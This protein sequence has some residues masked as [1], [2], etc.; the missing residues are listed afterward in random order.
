MSAYRKFSDG[1]EGHAPDHL[2]QVCARSQ[3]EAATSQTL[4]TLVAR[5]VGSDRARTLGG[6]G[7]LGAPNRSIPAVE[8]PRKAPP[9]PP[10]VPKPPKVIR[11][12]LVPVAY[13]AAFADLEKDCPTGV[14]A[15]RWQQCIQDAQRFFDGWGV[16][17]IALG[18]GADDL[19][20]LDPVA[21]LTR[22]DVMGLVWSLQGSPVVA[23]TADAAAIRMTSGAV[24]KF[25]RRTVDHPWE[26]RT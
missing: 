2:A 4:G 14:H 13:V 18:W 9:T 16:Q 12:D 10:K 19:F 1:W 15:A 5:E 25:Y 23:L 20:G 6:L 8:G 22:H 3:T 7:T 26:R 11:G 17:A 21:P 24:L